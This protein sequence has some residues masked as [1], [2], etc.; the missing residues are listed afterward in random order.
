MTWKQSDKRYSLLSYYGLADGLTLFHL[1]GQMLIFRVEDVALIL[2]LLL[3]GIAIDMKKA[4][5][6]VVRTTYFAGGIVRRDVLEDRIEELLSDSSS[7]GIRSTVQLLI[8]YL[9]DTSL[10]SLSNLNI[11]PWSFSTVDLLGD[12][13]RFA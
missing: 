8:S 7:N 6:S 3:N 10:F 4:P 11:A 1:E 2:E 9:L 12:I 13:G 5:H